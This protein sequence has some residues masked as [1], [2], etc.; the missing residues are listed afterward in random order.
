[1]LKN[2][3]KSKEQSQAINK[4]ITIILDNGHDKNMK[5]NTLNE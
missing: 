1:M 4:D 2:L 5:I 3:F